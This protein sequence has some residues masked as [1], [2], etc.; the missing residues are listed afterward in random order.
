MT[1]TLIVAI[2]FTIAALLSPFNRASR[3]RWLLTAAFAAGAV[4]NWLRYFEVLR[5]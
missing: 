5:S 3:H 2:L 1:L 4:I